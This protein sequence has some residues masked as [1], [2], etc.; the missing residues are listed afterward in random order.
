M[1]GSKPSSKAKVSAATEPVQVAAPAS[2]PAPAPASTS[3]SLPANTSATTKATDMLH[4]EEPD[5][6][7]QAHTDHFNFSRRFESGT[8]GT[9][10]NIPASL[11]NE[12][13]ELLEKERTLMELKLLEQAAESQHWKT[14]Y[15]EL[16]EIALEDIL[17]EK[18][19]Q[20]ALDK[21]EEMAELTMKDPPPLTVKDAS[22]ILISRVQGHVADLSNIELNQQVFIYLSRALF[23]VK[24]HK[25]YE[26]VRVLFVKNCELKTAHIEPLLHVLR[27]PKCEAIDISK[28]NINE[29]M[30]VKIL[31][32]LRVSLASYSNAYIDLSN[33]F[34]HF[35]SQSRKMTP[36]YLLLDGN[37][38][39]A[40]SSKS[41]KDLF[42]VLT[43]DTWGISISLQDHLNN[44]RELYDEYLAAHRK[45]FK[46][47][48]TLG[49][50]QLM[51]NPMRI[52]HFIG[53]LVEKVEASR[54]KEDILLG[55]YEGDKSK[56]KTK[57]ANTGGSGGKNGK[58]E[59]R[60]I[61]VF[62]G[63]SVL[64]LT[65][66]YIS[67]ASID[68]LERC[69]SIMPTL[70]DLDMSFSYM[71]YYGATVSIKM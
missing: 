35:V 45:K 9:T 66:N 52:L 59:A 3:T 18:S 34:Y 67:H 43:Y 41:F 6:E 42:E 26:D 64:G 12:V 36:Q 53:N 68:A 21:L 47:D 51:K 14:K 23:G 17:E 54:K 2:T 7:S 8:F 61:D 16:K 19:D 15:D 39:L 60:P 10:K 22:A 11:V 4:T 46:K 33:P 65:E 56:T 31:H 69:V 70:T 27:N 58:L 24:N 28:N 29:E 40:T 37:Q 32:T 38:S 1:T 49:F 5:E 55:I 20:I 44:P 50:R 57:K 13:E 30:L 25:Q 62:Q 48:P 63:L 71:G